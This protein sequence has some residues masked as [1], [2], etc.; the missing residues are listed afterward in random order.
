MSRQP[1]HVHVI[2]PCYKDSL[3]DMK[4]TL[5]SALS[6][7]MPPGCT[8]TIFLVDDSQASRL[9]GPSMLGPAAAID[10]WRAGDYEKQ[11]W[12]EEVEK[13]DS[14]IIYISSRLIPEQ[15]R[16]AKAGM[17]NFCLGKIYPDQA[18]AR[19][20]GFTELICV[21]KSDQAPKPDFFEKT[22]PLFDVNDNI[23]MVLTPTQ[24]SNTP[25]ATDIFNRN[26]VMG[27]WYKQPRY[28]G[29]SH[30][31]AMR[32]NVLI[33]SKA[34]METNGFPTY[35]CAESWAVGM[36]LKCS[37]WQGRY[38][39]DFLTTG[40]APHHLKSVFTDHNI[41]S[42]GALQVYF[43]HRNP[44]FRRAL[45]MPQR[46]LYVGHA[47]A[48][49]TAA[50]CTPVLMLVPVVTIWGGYFPLVLTRWVALAISV[51]LL[52]VHLILYNV[53]R[54]VHVEA[55]YFASLNGSLMWW[56][57]LRNLGEVVLGR[58]MPK[59]NAF[60]IS[61]VPGGEKADQSKAG[62]QTRVLEAVAVL[63]ATILADPGPAK[64]GSEGGYQSQPLALCLVWTL[65]NII[66]LALMFCYVAMR[67]HWTFMWA[68]IL[69]FFA[70]IILVGV[71]VI[72]LWVLLPGR[73]NFATIADDAT[74]SYRAQRVG[75]LPADNDVSWRA[76]ALAADSGPGGA[77]LTGGWLQGGDAGNLKLT[78]PTAFT[79]SMLAW[80]LV[81]FPSGY[82]T[83]TSR[84]K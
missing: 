52:A 82:K 40:E 34:L 67:K 72:L 54:I 73:M 9:Q 14:Q 30:I 53:R 12:C 43:S 63:L 22:L 57:Y 66:P 16:S 15:E 65:F 1:Y 27:W 58:V 25:F 2:I 24:F 61:K 62:I 51:Y 32:G 36:E 80:G 26:N 76:T 46:L 37:G 60:K 50:I 39:R 10:G 19:A 41:R 35:S 71:A 78:L 69:G 49:I 31:D 20:V 17:L 59:Y 77:D 7:T 83:E 21:F 11:R 13:S 42:K 8:R 6:A 84:A 4:T 81:A 18:T 79:T 33:R 45:S 3:T 23:G 48:F 55:A 28:D 29:W 38:L 68:C 56:T 74:F 64:L 5:L 47:W 44:F 75:T 70:S